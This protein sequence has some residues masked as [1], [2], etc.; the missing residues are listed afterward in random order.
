MSIDQSVDERDPWAARL[1]RE[2]AA[3]EGW[4]VSWWQKTGNWHYALRYTPT[5]EDRRRSPHEELEAPSPTARRL[6]DP[7][8]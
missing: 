2:P 1:D 4:R 3:G 6:P 8:P 5:A 7:A